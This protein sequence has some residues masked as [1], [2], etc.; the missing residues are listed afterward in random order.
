M[1]LFISNNPVFILSTYFFILVS[2]YYIY[3]FLE[4]LQPKHVPERSMGLCQ[5]VSLKFRCFSLVFFYSLLVDTNII[6]SL[7]TDFH[8]S[9]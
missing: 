5:T 3:I 8:F 7:V 6:D 2:V 1:I 4:R 9:L